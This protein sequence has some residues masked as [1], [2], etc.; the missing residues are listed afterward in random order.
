MPI[1]SVEDLLVVFQKR[2]CADN[3]QFS[4]DI[5]SKKAIESELDRKRN[6]GLRKLVNNSFRSGNK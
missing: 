5:Q 6:E 3:A 1:H 4:Q 2:C